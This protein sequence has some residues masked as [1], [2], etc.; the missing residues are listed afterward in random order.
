ML[1]D[2]PQRSSGES[3]GLLPANSRCH[4]GKLP[5]N[6]QQDFDT[7]GKFPTNSLQASD[8]FGELLASSA[9]S[10]QASDTFDK[11]LASL[12]VSSHYIV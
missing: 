11:L 6:A 8:P 9:N 4:P 12:S 5:T 7:F 1:F 3:L 10:G 2:N